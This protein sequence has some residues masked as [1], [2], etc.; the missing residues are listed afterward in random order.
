MFPRHNN[1]RMS[2][3]NRDIS[4]LHEEIRACRRCHVERFP[5]EGTPLVWGEAPAPFMVIGQA[6]SLTDLRTGRIYSGPAAQRLFGWLKEAGFSD[7]D[8]GRAI[9]LTA[10]TKCFPGRQHGR[11]VDRPPS[12]RE[13]ANCRPWLLQELALVRPQVAIL[14]GK[15]AIDEFLGVGVSLAERIG[16]RF[17][18]DGR[19]TSPC[20]TRPGRAPG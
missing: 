12:A 5:V 20:R 17:E 14:F 13:R 3:G 8:F 16:R 7:E 2:I 1:S 4:R 18:Q 9:Y 15:M 6:P 11:S 10:L 19:P